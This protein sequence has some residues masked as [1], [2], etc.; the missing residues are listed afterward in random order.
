M[1]RGLVGAGASAH[2]G[3]SLL[4]LPHLLNIFSGFLF[5]PFVPTPTSS[6][7]LPFP[8]QPAANLQQGTTKGLEAQ[9]SPLPPPPS[10]ALV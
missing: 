9:L 1:E 10:G 8:T 2:T 3:Y 7:I 6:L 5:S 4:S